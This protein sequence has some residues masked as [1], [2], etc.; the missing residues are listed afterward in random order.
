M[1]DER[2]CDHAVVNSR[3]LLDR[4]VAVGA[5]S[6]GTVVTEQHDH[7]FGHHDEPQAATPHDTPRTTLQQGD[8]PGL[9]QPQSG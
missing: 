1:G 3:G 9:V 2:H 4:H 6:G 7:A 5:Y 8:A